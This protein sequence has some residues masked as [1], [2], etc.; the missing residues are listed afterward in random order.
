METANRFFEWSAVAVS[1]RSRTIC[2]SFSDHA[3]DASEPTGPQKFRF[4]SMLRLL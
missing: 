4:R 3:G 1:V 2:V